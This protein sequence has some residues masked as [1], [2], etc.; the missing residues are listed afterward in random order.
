MANSSRNLSRESM[1]HRFDYLLST[2]LE[3]LTE[4]NF[5]DMDLNEEELCVEEELTFCDY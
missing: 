4:H 1:E 2:V 5:E 3:E